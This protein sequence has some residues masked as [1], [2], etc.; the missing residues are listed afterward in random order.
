MNIFGMVGAGVKALMGISDKGA[1][2]VMEVARG[3][4]GWIDEQKFTDEEKAKLTVQQ[5]EM[6]NEYVA[7]TAQESTLRSRTRRDMALLIIRAEL[8]F[9]VVYGIL[10][11][12][13]NEAAKVWWQI[14]TDSPWGMLTLGVGAFFWGT[15]MLRSFTGAK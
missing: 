12:I 5:A 1:D 10:A 3:V 2:N 13:G 14:A 9:L 15:H 8:V 6:M 7:A 4:G 11:S